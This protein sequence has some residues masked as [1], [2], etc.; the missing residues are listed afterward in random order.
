MSVAR[1]IGTI[2][3]RSREEFDKR[4]SWRNEGLA[5]AAAGK[6]APGIDD[7]TWELKEK[8]HKFEVERYLD[9]AARK[10]VGGDKPPCVRRACLASLVPPLDRSR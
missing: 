8:N 5:A 10:F 9:N 6:A 3:Y 2:F 4:F 1:Q 7:H